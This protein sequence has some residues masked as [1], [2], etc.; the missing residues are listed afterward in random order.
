MG[1]S[2]QILM[3]T[4]LPEPQHEE[5][6]SKG[7]PSPR[8]ERDRSASG[9]FRSLMT[10]VVTISGTKKCTAGLLGINSYVL[11][12]IRWRRGDDEPGQVLSQ[13]DQ[14]VTVERRFRDFVWLDGFIR[15]VS[16]YF[17]M[18]LPILPEKKSIGT[19]DDTFI[20]RRRVELEKY[21]R[22][23]ATHD[24]LSKDRAFRIFIATTDEVEFEREKAA[25]ESE[26]RNSSADQ[27]WSDYLQS[28]LAYLKANIKVNLSHQQSLQIP[29]TIAKSYSNVLDLEDFLT[30][31]LNNLLG[32]LESRKNVREGFDAQIRQTRPRF[33]DTSKVTGLVVLGEEI[34]RL[35]K[36]GERLAKTFSDERRIQEYIA[37]VKDVITR[38]AGL[39]NA[40]SVL[41]TEKKNL[42]L[43]EE[44]MGARERQEASMKDPKSPADPRPSRDI[45]RHRE[46]ISEMKANIEKINSN[47]QKELDTF[48]TEKPIIVAD[49]IRKYNELSLSIWKEKTSLDSDDKV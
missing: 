31:T 3:G 19:F 41:L 36:E 1:R 20:E 9:I 22:I 25:L 28:Q 39:K 43:E 5:R 11:Y 4:S 13:S 18:V 6:K 42:V 26:F 15:K 16:T 38:I 24:I 17:G 44:L 47:L 23:L 12:V 45:E 33:E 14:L 10:D 30:R 8:E 46:K 37:H 21:L 32:L 27:T 7:E 48:Q 40:H 34:D 35:G 29:E 2:S 49:I